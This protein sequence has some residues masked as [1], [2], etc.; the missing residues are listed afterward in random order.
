MGIF[1]FLKKEEKKNAQKAVK[2]SGEPK[3]DSAI[4]RTDLAP[5]P[6]EKTVAPAV[7]SAEASAK[8][9]SAAAEKILANV[10]AQDKNR[11]SRLLLQ[12][13]TSEKTTR[14]NAQRQYT[15]EVTTDATK[16]DIARA[17]KAVYGVVPVK[18]NVARGK[19]KP[20]RSGRFQGRRK[21]WKKAIV[22]LREGESI[23]VYDHV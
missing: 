8:K 4:V 1:N 11:A 15:F 5:A 3:P 20:V 14:L 17:V 9:T 21:R 18:V 7:K 6:V 12:P 16:I 19:G 13:V 23:Q 22:T 10:S 2:S